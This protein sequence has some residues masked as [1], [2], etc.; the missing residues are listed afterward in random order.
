MEGKDT[1][2]F[3]EKS[4]RRANLLDIRCHGELGFQAEM[5]PFRGCFLGA[6]CP[7]FCPIRWDV[8][9]DVWYH[10]SFFILAA[11]M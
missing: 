10:W 4:V 2:A 7:D 11:C 6:G 3:L 1:R 8:P 9:L 5:P